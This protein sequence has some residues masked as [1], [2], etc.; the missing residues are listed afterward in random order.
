MTSLKDTYWPPYVPR[1][2]RAPHTPLIDNLITSARRYPNK[3]A[4]IFLQQETSYAELLEQV[5][6]MAGYL[7]Q[8]G[9]KRGDRVLLLMQNCPQLVVAH[10]AILRADAVVV[11][12]NPMNRAQELQHY[13]A[14]SQAHVAVVAEDLAHEL[15]QASAELAPPQRLQHVVTAR[16]ADAAGELHN[17]AVA[18]PQ[19][20]RDWFAAAVTPAQWGTTQAHA[21][22]QVMAA[23]HTPTPVQNGPEDLAILPYTSGTTG[24]PK[25]CM[26]PQRTVMYNAHAMGLWMY[27]T[28]E[29]VQLV[30][31]PMFHITGLVIGMHAVIAAGA[32]MVIMPRWDRD[33]AGAAI[34]HWG[35][36]H[37][38]N[39][40]TMVIDLLASPHAAN[41][42]LNSL[43]YI[44]GGGAAMPQAV[45]QR[46][47][48]QYGLRYAE[49]YGL[50][51]TCAPSHSNPA[52]ATRQ[53]CLGVPYMDAD[54][55]VV[56][57]DT[58][59]PVA[60][61][62]PGEILIQGPMVFNGYW[63]NPEATAKAFAEVQ[64]RR[65][66]RS[67]DLGRVDEQGF[68]YMTDRLKRMI[69]ASGYKVWPAEVEAMMFQHPAI[70]EACIISAPDAYRGETVQAVVVLR[71]DA[72]ATAD[73]IIA[74]C[75]DHMA[76][77]KVPRRVQLIDALPKSGSG[78]VMWRLLQEQAWAQTES[79]S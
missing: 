36:T 32:S 18:I 48:E 79:Q 14:D 70:A 67:G 29:S 16:Y 28:P 19:A 60:P 17:A 6:R 51:E 61:G 69:N 40:P 34:A 45:A 72:Q 49:A 65:Y 7:Q 58:L 38:L 12:V 64:G 75:R 74:W 56:N 2:F 76:A 42:P 15:A 52:H 59:Q 31:V 8:L 39:I 66:F 4:L 37:W 25:G 11:P 26:H 27:Q 43:Q 55:I 35:V 63:R 68:F 41:Y 33:Y 46:L 5:E 23:A 44:G 57:P 9:V 77:Y 22:P 30:A 71:Q 53:Q 10:F 21:W 1:R 54:A 3:A 20:W 50:T 73:D 78:K 62:E 13:I 47:L 24:L